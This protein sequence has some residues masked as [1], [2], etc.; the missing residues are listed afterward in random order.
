MYN[1]INSLEGKDGVE[2]VHQDGHKRI[3]IPFIIICQGV[4][5]GLR[6]NDTKEAG[7]HQTYLALGAVSGASKSFT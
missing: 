3:Q 6:D 2:G 4:G 1:R 5:V 7:E